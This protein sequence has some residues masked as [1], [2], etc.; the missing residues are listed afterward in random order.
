MLNA[1]W[2]IFVADKVTIESNVDAGRPKFEL[3]CLLRQERLKLVAKNSACQQTDVR[4]VED[5]KA[6]HP[7]TGTG[8]NGRKISVESG[9]AND[10]SVTNDFRKP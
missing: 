6:E 1:L 8:R 7:S 3:V 5:P 10:E 2:L 9:P 4:L